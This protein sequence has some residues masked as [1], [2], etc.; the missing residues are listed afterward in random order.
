MAQC[1]INMKESF[2]VIFHRCFILNYTFHDC[3][4]GLN[5]MSV[6][7][8]NNGK[9]YQ[10]FFCFLHIFSYSLV[11]IGNVFFNVDN[12]IENKLQKMYCLRKMVLHIFLPQVNSSN[13]K[14]LYIFFY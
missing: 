9:R 5:E 6:N 8:M 1:T 7:L 13:F 14:D 2:V 3:V 10:C 11:S 12:R 4:L